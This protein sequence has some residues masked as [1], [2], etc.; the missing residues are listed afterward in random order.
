VSQI[1][2]TNPAIQAVDRSSLTFVPLANTTGD[3]I[4]GG[5]AGAV[6]VAANSSIVL[7]GA[8][9]QSSSAL[10]PAIEASVMSSIILAG[11]NNICA[12]SLSGSACTPSAGGTAIEV[13]HSASL[14]HQQG[15]TLGFGNGAE[16]IT[17]KGTTLMQSSMEL[18]QGPVGGAFGLVWTGVLSVG[19]NSAIRMQSGVH[20]TGAVQISAASNGYFNCNNN[21]GSCSG[22]G[23]QNEIDGTAECL[24]LAASPDNPS[25]HV[26]NPQ[27]IVNSSLT[28]GSGVA[29]ANLFG[30]SSF[31]TTATAANTC[32][33]F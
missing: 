8:S 14:L 29:A 22:T 6:L 10:Q 9:I 13:D 24:E 19:Q 16:S 7:N 18:G 33:N 27:L 3:S 2:A 32:L 23:A 17:G 30:A 31:A 4:S 11:G 12:G 1:S 5:S 26:S 20:I 21:G 15:N 25:A 28:A